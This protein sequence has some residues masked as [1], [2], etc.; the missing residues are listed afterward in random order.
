ME[1]NSTNLE[2]KYQIKSEI[3]HVLDKSGMWIGSINGE[4]IRYPLFVPSKNKILLLNNIILNAGLIKL[5]DEVLSNSI[6]EYRRRGKDA[7]FDITEISVKI[8]EDGFIEI[9]DNGGI[10]V[11]KH[12]QTGIL[13][14]ELIFGH[15]RTSS[16]Y[17]DSK[18]REVVG[19]NGLGSKLTNIFS[20]EFNVETCDGKNKVI[21]NW[22]NNMRE[23]NKDIE[24]YPKTCGFQVVPT[25]EHYTKT[26]FKLDLNRFDGI[27][28]IDN[29]T[30]RIIQKKCID[31][32]ASNIGLK[33]NFESNIFDGKLNSYWQFDSFE[34]YVKLYLDKEQYDLMI[35]C[36]MGRN[37]TIIVPDYLGFNIG[38]VNGVLCSEGT[39]IKKI[40]KQLTDI[41]LTYCAKNEME[42]I[43][44]KDILNR[45]TI[46]SN[47]TI[48]NPTY[49][50]QSKDKLTNKL[51]KYQLLFSKEFN[52]KILNSEIIK[53]LKDFYEVKYA[54]E[55]K[56]ET[57]KLNNTIRQTKTKKLISCASR[58]KNTNELWL[59]EGN[60]AS[61]GFRKHR[62]LYQSAYLL[63]GKIKNTFNLQR[64]QV[65]ENV[66]LREIIAASGLLFGEPQKNLKNVNFGKFVIASDMDY[67]GHHI[68][69]LLIAFFAKFFPELFKAGK[70]Y[71]ALSP[72][73]IAAHPGKSK[74]YY[75]S[76]AEFAK[77]EQLV[78]G[79][80]I[81]YTK[82]LGGL[83]DEDYRQ[84]LRNQ[85]LI[86]FKIE[87][88]MYVE[89][90]AVWF[91]KSTEQRKELIMEDNGEF[92]E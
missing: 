52:D 32:A 89:S 59:F 43:T 49:D 63:R 65:L 86:Q 36:Q 9:K 77:E 10:S 13:I 71:R 78:K 30:I 37:S 83:D 27:E 85:K 44:E 69:G 47:T 80:D 1:N 48:I 3:E 19:T 22:K 70:V 54:E 74:K 87:D 40:E 18:N 41:I 81:T 64:T 28:K 76:M 68:C 24:K 55:K 57:R 72:I 51:D 58:D 26:T 56:K 17:D 15:L 45:I 5:I 20:K 25:K 46:F 42:L 75:Y 91:D 33:I 14:P 6:D 53:L 34:E 82:G 16:N 4:L 39:H 7:L 73:I 62:S 92:A 79:W 11:T 29:S 90:I 60:S 88:A 8:L 67:D 61:N 66:E 31:S 35:G 21:I 38:F 84:M 23:S 2:G 12:K 50:S